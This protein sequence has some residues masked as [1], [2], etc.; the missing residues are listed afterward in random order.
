MPENSQL[1]DFE[2][3]NFINDILFKGITFQTIVKLSI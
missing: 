2:K 3:M 1:N